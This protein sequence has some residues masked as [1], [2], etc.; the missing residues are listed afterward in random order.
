MGENVV[1]FEKFKAAKNAAQ[2]QIVQK[3]DKNHVDWRRQIFPTAREK[4]TALAQLKPKSTRSSLDLPE[5]GGELKTAVTQAHKQFFEAD[6]KKLNDPKIAELKQK[7]AMWVR[8]RADQIRHWLSLAAQTTQQITQRY[9]ESKVTSSHDA[10]K[11]P[12]N[13]IHAENRFGPQAKRTGM[14]MKKVS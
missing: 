9:N 3:S 11:Q 13:L 5:Q 12:D 14:Q 7:D 8:K 10:G 1:S 4:L 2:E 6:A